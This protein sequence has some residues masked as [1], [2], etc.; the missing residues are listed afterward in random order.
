MMMTTHQQSLSINTA[1]RGSIEVTDQVAAIVQ[2]SGVDTGICQIFIRHTSASLMITEN[3]APA[4]RAD[5]ETLLARFA[6]DGD[7]DYQHDD[8]GADDMAAHARSVLT[9]SGTS[10][11]VGNR[12]L[13]LGTWQGIYLFEHRVRPHRR[14]LVVTVIGSAGP[15]ER[16]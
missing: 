10:I 4:V 1:G 9:G 3:A 8:E 6:P 13:L 12:R 16:R 11:P 14:E 5:L 7:P 2:A 15:D